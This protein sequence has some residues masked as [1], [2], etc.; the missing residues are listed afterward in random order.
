[1]MNKLLH[2]STYFELIREYRKNPNKREKGHRIY[3]I[4]AYNWFLSLG[5]EEAARDIVD[6]KRNI[7]GRN[8]MSWVFSDLATAEKKYMML[9][10]RWS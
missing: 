2:K 4:R 7:G 6:P 5:E 8:G 10:M 3:R 9:I 1:M